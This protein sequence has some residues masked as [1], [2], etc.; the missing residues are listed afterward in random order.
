MV[1]KLIEINS[2]QNEQLLL[3]KEVIQGLKDEIA[4]LKGEKPKPKIKPSNLGK[5]PKQDDNING[6]DNEKAKRPGSKKK[7]KKLKTHKTVVV[8]PEHIPEGSRF[9]GYE[10]YFVQD[11]L[12]QPYNVRY[13]L[14]RWITSSGESIVGTLPGGI[15]QDH[16]GYRLIRY[17]LY[18]YHHSLV[19]QPLILEELLEIGIDISS[20]KI[21]QILIEGKEDF[22][23]EKEDILNAGLEV[24]GYVNVDDTGARH[25]GR[26][27][28]CT[29][30]GNEWFAWFGSTESKSR[31]NFLTL[32]RGK[33][34]DYVLNQEA[35]DYMQAHKL[36][37]KVL[38]SLDALEGK[39][40][41]EQ[42]AWESIL[43]RLGITNNR[44]VQI[45]TEGALLGSILEHGLNKYLVILSD[46]AGQFNV[47]L[48][49]LCWI[50]AER[51]INKLV[52]FNE[53]Q[54]EALNSVRD[55]LWTLYEDLKAYKEEPSPTKKEDL[56][57][58][59][60]KLFTTKTCFASLNLALKKIYDNKSELLL[61]LKR[62]EIPL[63]NNLSEN[64][65][66]E[67]V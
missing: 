44:H 39:N 20:G 16:F 12:I 32:L 33:Q 5:K 28:Y 37:Q 60:D 9:K 57:Q 67:F 13:R 17:I 36:P 61:V 1:D 50:H 2:F 8:P 19:T 10:D 53:Q 41:P 55:E 14:E 21:S 31:I 47:F 15:S 18:Q 65:I 25:K 6:Q 45:A 30:I 63:H 40:L 62:P 66:R 38:Q 51:T 46:D 29:H 35:L 11:I 64:D 22:H 59:F 23:A 4:R 58:R 34:T 24:S 52:G 56:E 26:N 27:G 49:A 54:R 43:N 48:H 3:Q 7:R 42:Q